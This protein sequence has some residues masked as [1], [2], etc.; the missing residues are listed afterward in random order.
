MTSRTRNGP[1][2]RAERSIRTFLIADI[3]GYTAFTRER[4]DEAAAILASRFAEVVREGVEAWDGEL[5]ELRGDEALAVFGSARRALRCAVELQDA[6]SH[7]VDLDPSLPL[8]VGM[9]LD[10]GEAVPVEEGYRGGAL[11]L[12]ARLCSHAMAG[13]VL[14]SDGVVHL[15]RAT[16]GVRFEPVASLDLK[17][18]GS[19]DVVRVVAADGHPPRPGP[20]PSGD[21]AGDLP[22]ALSASPSVVGRARELRWLRWWWR[23]TVHG[24]GRLVVLDGPEGSGKTVLAA[25]IAAEVHAAGRRVTYVS[26]AEPSDAAVAELHA[27]SETGGLLVI[28]DVD[29]APGVVLDAIRRLELEGADGSF[30]VLTCRDTR[31]PVVRD[32]IARVDPGGERHRTLGPL[33]EGDVLQI[34][35]AYASD[36][37]HLPLDRIERETDFQPGPVHRWLRSWVD[38]RARQRLEISATQ[39]AEQGERMDRAASQLTE[40]VLELQLA[41]A[42]APIDLP[43]DV[44][45]YKG[46]APFDDDDVD[47]FFGREQL[48]SK[49]VAALITAPFLGVTGP[50]GSGKSSLVRAGLVPAIAAGSLPGSDRWRRLVMRPGEHPIRELERALGTTLPDEGLGAATDERLL[51]VVDQFEEI[52]TSCSDEEERAAFVDVLTEAAERSDGPVSI[53]VAIRADFYGRC[54]AYPALASLLGDHHVLVGPMEPDELRR[55]IELPAVRVGLTVEHELV[56]ALVAEVTDEPGGL[57]LL[58]TTLLELWLRRSGRV[59]TLASFQ[60]SGGVRGAVARLAE[61]A[62]ERL[63]DRQRQVA[64]AILLRSA[65]PG[66][67]AA[68]VRRRV[69]LTELDVQ[70]DEDVAHVLAALTDARL[71]TTTETTVEVAHEAL[72][73]EWPRLRDW[74]EENAEGR[75]LHLHLAQTVGEWQEGGRDPADLFRGARLASALDWTAEHSLELNEAERE[76]LEESRGA[77]ERAAERQRR[78]NRRLQGLL[79]GTAVLL[80]VALIAGSLAISQ[81]RVAQRAERAS[82]ARELANASRANL[83]V[84]PERSVLLATQAVN[85]TRAVDGTVVQEAELA[86]HDAIDGQRI[87]LTIPRFNSFDYSPDGR[88]VVAVQYSEDGGS[89]DAAILDATTGERLTTLQ[90]RGG[91]LWDQDWS[92]D[93]DVV[94]TLDF[95]GLITQWDPHDGTVVRTIQGPKNPAGWIE[96]SPDGTWVTTNTLDGIY[97]VWDVRTGHLVMSWKSN[98]GNEPGGMAWSPDGHRLAVDPRDDHSIQVVDVDSGRLV[99]ER[100]NGF[101]WD[102]AWSPDGSMIVTGGS[103]MEAWDAE[104]GNHLFTIFPGA[105]VLDQDFG[106]DGG[107]L[108]GGSVDGTVH[109][110]QIERLWGREV[111]TLPSDVS[112]VCCVSFSPDGSHVIAGSAGFAAGN[113]GLVGRVWDVTSAGGGERLTLPTRDWWSLLAYSPDGSTIAITTDGGLALWD[114]DDGRRIRTIRTETATTGVSFSPDGTG[115][116]A[117]GGFGAAIWDVPTGRLE[118]RLRTGKAWVGHVRFSSD[119]TSLVTASDDGRARVFDAATGALRTVLRDPLHGIADAVLSP[120][121]ETVATI[122]YDPGIL[123]LWDASTGEL[124]RSIRVGGAF[125][126]AIAYS[127]DGRT[128]AI[129]L[130]DGTV[131]LLDARGRDRRVFQAHTADVTSIDFDPDDRRIVTTSLDGLVKIWDARTGEMILTLTGHS[132]ETNGGTFSPDGRYVASTSTDGTVRVWILD[133]DELLDLAQRRV[134][135]SLTAAECRRY[136]HGPCPSAA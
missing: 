83:T 59:L 28:D 127:H 78:T 96:L 56:D 13:E 110:W 128:L 35:T 8:L 134:T 22:T 42:A 54:A 109:I 135:R 116:A 18:L 36:V 94:V 6:F 30:V 103:T 120:D 130:G 3:R 126:R 62:Y 32:L 9:G 61:T 85:A 80:V 5:A 74:L 77:A 14:A 113:T 21:G 53:V 20:V 33:R 37:G 1:P 71:L 60:E 119:G 111:L 50:S 118:T 108:A 65:G 93:G 45:P 89:P 67:G 72:L 81:R 15:A 41:R 40:D 82:I 101:G 27:A 97:D 102:V 4:G 73:R 58:S 75:R 44:C 46:L 11:N 48:V 95:D 17:G 70:R 105:E 16:E 114:V 55:A 90:G 63:T 98:G 69:P 112:T 68:A 39:A 86:L 29:A 57:P 124:R 92:R 84:D 76:F 121:G 133:I 51:L 123:R 43:S 38:S 47:Y 7:E 34:A 52:F 104:S 91:P 79:A 26:S 129:G 100:S 106:P 122:K 10:A 19:Q 31:V 66:E 107:F 87:R 12:A 24:H 125:I 64:R 88:R 25:A 132:A 2:T 131:H 115:V 99:W 49:L 23:R 117:S 136:L